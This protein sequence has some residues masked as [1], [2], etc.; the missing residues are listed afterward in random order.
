[1]LTKD[2]LNRIEAV[3]DTKCRKVLSEVENDGFKEHMQMDCL[4]D[5]LRGIRKVHQLKESAGGISAR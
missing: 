3:L 2:E 5:C 1:M 4:L